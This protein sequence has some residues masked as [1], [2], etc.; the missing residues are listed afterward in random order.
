MWGRHDVV[1]RM[2]RQGEGSDLVQK[3]FRG[4][5]RQKIGTKTDELLQAGG[6]WAR[7]STARC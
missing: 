3:M 5:V 7:K 4:N 6:K 1:G 2:D